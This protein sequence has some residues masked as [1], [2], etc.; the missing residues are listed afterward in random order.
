[1]R[2]W[3]VEVDPGDRVVLYVAGAGGLSKST[4]GGAS[5]TLLLPTERH[6]QAI[7]VSPADPGLVYLGLVASPGISS[8]FWFLRSRDGGATWDQLEEHHNSL[9]GW[10]VPILVPHPTEPSRVFRAASCLAGRDF[11]DAL[12]HSG[13]QGA[14]WARVFGATRLDA[15]DPQLAYPARLVGGRGATPA[16]YY[17]A[18]NRD[19]RFGGS[20]LF[21]G[22]DD[23]RTWTEVL[24]F[25]GG[26]TMDRPEAQSIRLGGLAYE[27]ARSDRVYVGFNAYAGEATGRTL[28]D[29]GV[30][31][32]ASGGTWTDLGRRS[33]GEI[34]DLALDVDGRSLYLATDRGVWRL[35]LDRIPPPQ[36]PAQVPSPA[37]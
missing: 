23:G 9:C 8:D 7:A 35:R 29:S 25:R 33:L 14:T 17:L 20:S 24:A 26:G 12:W 28:A 37:R 22:D 2:S 31:M 27:P 13:D 34:N 36:P 3:Q 6:A 1:M 16:R 4:D 5:W 21:R 10:G 30:M 11:G 15:A 32:S 18:A 19:A